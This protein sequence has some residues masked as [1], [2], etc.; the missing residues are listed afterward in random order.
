MRPA[1]TSARGISLIELMVA[2]VVTAFVMVGVV[3]TVSAQQRAYVGGQQTREM[4]QSIR[5]ALLSIERNLRL[6]GYGMDPALALDFAWYGIMEP[7]P[8]NGC[9]AEMWP[10]G[11]DATRNA[12]ELVFYA[13]N[14]AFRYPP[15]GS[16]ALGK[17]WSLVSIAAGSATLQARN[18]ETFRKGQILQAVCGSIPS[19]YLY[20]TLNETKTAPGD[21]PLTIA[22]AA[23]NVNDP[24]RRQDLG[25]SGT[26]YQCFLTTARVFQIDRY[27][28]HLRP[29]KQAATRY[30][31]YLV[32]DTGTDTNG[33]NS[34]D[35]KDEL[36]VADAIEQMQV[37]YVFQNPVLAPVGL[38]AGTAILFPPE[39]A[40]ATTRGDLTAGAIATTVFP[41]APPT[42]PERSVYSSSSWFGVSSA[43]PNRLTN[44]QANLK[45][46]R[47][48]LLARAGEPMPA[49]KTNLSLIGQSLFNFL[50]TATQPSWIAAGRAGGPDD[51]YLRVRL[52]TTVPLENM[53]VRGMTAF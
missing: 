24:F 50:G 33:D 47:L 11:R 32:L 29:Y 20:F 17:T 51:K 5:V 28:Y 45:S 25:Y 26:N 40:G 39:V 38:D 9:P 52:E 41:L 49:S 35:D 48:L 13:R 53:S 37:G 30:D 34:V 7:L 36:F 6:A 42:R 27:R 3:A 21:G 31:P 14:P 16:A 18:G 1:R 19:Y 23:Q 44:H 2:L 22:L 10:C 8:T 43:D 12:D 4:Q 46:V 15:D